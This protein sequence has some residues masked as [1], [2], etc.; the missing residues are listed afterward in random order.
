MPGLAVELGVLTGK[1]ILIYVDQFEEIFT[2]CPDED[3]AVFLDR[4][5]PSAD[6]DNAAFRL[7]CTLR[8]DFL[9]RLLDHAGL[10]LAVTCSTI[11]A[12]SSPWPSAPMAIPWPPAPP[13]DQCAFS[14]SVT[15]R[16]R[17]F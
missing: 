7:V 5:L 16:N 1:R 15:P 14:T 4:V 9:G 12:V 8:T 11:L 6:V 2:T 3:R 17:L 10:V 13:T